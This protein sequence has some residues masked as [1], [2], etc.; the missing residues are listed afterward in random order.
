MKKVV[1]IILLLAMVTTLLAG[2]GG[3]DTKDTTVAKIEATTV[4]NQTTEIDESKEPTGE[5]VFR[6]NIGSDPKTLDP[7][8]NGAN[9]AGNVIAQTFEGLIRER[10]G[11]VYEGIA[12][13]WNVSDD[14]LTV[15]FHLRKSNWSDGS[16]LTAQDFLYSFLRGMNPL[17]ASEYS[18]IWE[19]T[20][21]V[22]A[23][24]LVNIGVL[25][26]DDQKDDEKVKKHKEDV[27]NAIKN[28]GI[29]APDDYTLV[30]TLAA[31]TDYIISLLSFYHFMPVKKASVE[32][33]DLG[34]WA[35]D[36]SAVICN[37]PFKLTE[38]T[39]GKG[40]TLTKNEEYWNA[41][42]VKLDRID[43][44]FVDDA[45][46]AYQAYQTGELDFIPAVPV[47]EIP[48]LM[49]EDPN[50]HIFPLLG[51]YYMN[52]NLEKEVWQD[53]RVRRAFNLAINR[54]TICE[55]LGTGQVPALGFV[56]PGFLDDQGRDFYETSGSYGLVADDSKV[57]EAKKLLSDA[58]YPNGEGFPE[59]TILFNTS[60]GHQTVAQ[61]I[62]E[63]FKNNLGIKC[64]LANQ[65]WAVFQDTRKE[66][67][68][69]IARGGWLT[70]YMD[71]S[72]LLSI[73]TSENAYNDPSFKNAKYDELLSNSASSVG[74]DHF[75]YLYEAQKILM[76]ELPIIPIYHY[77]ESFLTREYVQGWDR[78][79]LGA[80]DFSQAFIS[81]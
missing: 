17:T 57:E 3:E 70:D 73:F 45:A 65:E 20:N 80:I 8:L 7:T 22:G 11:I 18:W 25:S 56:A 26:E 52:F 58:G 43:A 34:A 63:M 14:G 61:L 64:K 47:A 75:N 69:E 24:D 21:I 15:T 55:T 16:P 74:A 46:T 38:Y 36:P 13:K 53:K 62:Q 28:V 39:I 23:T 72:G 4:T 6:W 41:K 9:D 33:A 76:E 78:S 31:K 27:E 40:L 30:F 37:G 29:K 79:V 77:T 48:K 81:K 5:Q 19:Y 59:F 50:F 49:A 71:P 42:S 68:F 12:E 51:T 66:G 10:S 44:V 67:N 1:S 32:T 2:C 35:K 60:Q 54:E